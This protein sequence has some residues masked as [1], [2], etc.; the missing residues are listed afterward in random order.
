MVWQENSRVIV[1]TTKEMERGK[2]VKSTFLEPIRVMDGIDLFFFLF[3]AVLGKMC[4]I[5]ARRESVQRVRQNSGQVC[6]RF[7]SG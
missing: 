2:V 3:L 7:E 1:M 5:L 4:P 6:K